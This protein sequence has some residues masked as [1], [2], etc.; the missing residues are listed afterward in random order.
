MSSADF[1]S[2][3]TFQKILSGIPSECQMDWIQIRTDILSG[4]GRVQSVCNGYEQMTLVVN[5][6]TV[7]M[8]NNFAVFLCRLQIFFKINFSKNFFQKHYQSVKWFG[9][10]SGQA[11]SSNIM[12]N[13]NSGMEHVLKYHTLTLTTLYQNY[14]YQFFDL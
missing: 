8:M 13:H 14:G 4:L 1:F 7:C 6:S 11:N 9:S 12:A 2:K 3:L 10:R 5:E